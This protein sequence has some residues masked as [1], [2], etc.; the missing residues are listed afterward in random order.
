MHGNCAERDS[1]EAGTYHRRI[2][3]GSGLWCRQCGRFW[4][5]DVC[6]ESYNAELQSV[7]GAELTEV[8]GYVTCCCGK[9]LFKVEE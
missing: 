6:G 4:A 1:N 7:D 5:N 9:R 8:D 2:C 3:G